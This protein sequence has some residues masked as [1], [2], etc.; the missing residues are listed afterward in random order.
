MNLN[1]NHYDKTFSISPILPPGSVL[2]CVFA[3]MTVHVCLEVN[4]F[5]SM[6]FE[7]IHSAQL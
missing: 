3:S 1:T 4:V 7:Y 5:I 2:L 6:S